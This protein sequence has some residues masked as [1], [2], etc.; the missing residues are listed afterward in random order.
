MYYRNDVALEESQAVIKV[1]NPLQFVKIVG[2][3]PQIDFFW[4]EVGGKRRLIGNPNKPMRKLHEL[5]GAYI[6][7]G[8]EIMGDGNYPLH[9][10]PSSTG[11]VKG[12]NPLKNA[13]KHKEGKFFYVTD[14]WN[15]YPSVDIE[16]LAALIVY[17]MKYNEYKIDFSLSRLGQ[18][19]TLVEE[20]R[21]DALFSS[22]HGLL[23]SFFSGIRGEG[24]AVGGPLS[25]FLFNLYCEVYADAELR[26]VCRKY[27]I[28]FT[29]YADDNVFSRNKPI[30]GKIRRELRECI[31]RAGF[32]VNHRKSKVLSRAMGT[33][34]VTKIGLQDPS[35]TENQSQTAT[36][37][38]PKKKRRLL[39]GIIGSY[40]TM[41]MD[42]PEKVSGFIAEFLY[43][44]KNVK[45]PTA[46]DRKTFALCKKFEEEWAKHR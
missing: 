18:N 37:V 7:E 24:L 25:P 19:V 33:V 11:F 43:Y 5:F 15:A 38:F 40:L 10:L 41:Q 4:K 34:F 23:E 22:V 2:G 3:H 8:I 26:L 32:R 45:E 13:Q 9:K 35:T 16:R 42:W 31:I 21:N 36:F 44:F 28:T 30:I 17:I 27:G 29:R 1:F 46:T 14:I 39:H 12:S 20:L 6:R